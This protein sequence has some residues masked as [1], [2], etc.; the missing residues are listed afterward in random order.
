[1]RQCGACDFCA[2]MIEGESLTLSN[3]SPLKCKY[4]A[5]CNKLGV[6][7]VLTCICGAYYIDKAIYTVCR[8]LQ[9]HLYDIFTYHLKAPVVRHVCLI[10][11]RVSRSLKCWVLKVVKPSSRGGNFDQVILKEKL[12]D[13]LLFLPFLQ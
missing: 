1:M 6:I 5:D 11:S 4:Q 10:H 2:F 3:A 7:Y 12:N 8:R 13:I 9:N